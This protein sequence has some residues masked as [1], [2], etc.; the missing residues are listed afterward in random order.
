V[1]VTA[2]GYYSTAPSSVTPLSALWGTCYQNEATSAISVTG[3]L[4]QCASGA[5]GTF[6]V[7]ANDPPFPNIECLA[8]TPCGGGCPV[9]GTAQLTCP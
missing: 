7:W 4:A 3:G 9:V 8:V 6:T 1:Q 5:I 2:T